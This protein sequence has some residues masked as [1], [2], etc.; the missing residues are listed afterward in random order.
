[1]A[2][3]GS[4]PGTV[5]SFL[6]AFQP[7]GGDHGDTHCHLEEPRGVGSGVDQRAMFLRALGA[8]ICTTLSTEGCNVCTPHGPRQYQP[9]PRQEGPSR[10][11]PHQAGTFELSLVLLLHL[12]G[13]CSTGRAARGQQ[14]GASSTGR[15]CAGVPHPH[16][17][18][19]LGQPCARCLRRG[20]QPSL[21]RSDMQ[22]ASS[23]SRPGLWRAPYLSVA[24][25]ETRRGC[26]PASPLG[27]YQNVPSGR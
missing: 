11:L 18:A 13:A 5:G 17:R 23:V 25:M 1:M 12:S 26:G 14:Q 2:E 6:Q 8:G 21:R 15:A 9:P 27:K 4:S 10:E 3:N 16:L 7:L 19:P 22:A 20:A 24:A